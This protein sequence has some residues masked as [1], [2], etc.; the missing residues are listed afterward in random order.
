[1]LEKAKHR[2]RHLTNVTFRRLPLSLRFPL[3]SGSVDFAYF[4]HVS[5][6][7]DREDAFMILREMRRVLRRSGRA[8]VQFSLLRHPDNQRQFQRWAVGDDVADVRSRFYTEPEAEL[9][10]GLADLHP[11]LRLYI[12]GEYA[13]IVTKTDKR[14]LGAMPLVRLP[15]A[16]DDRR[17]PATS[18]IGKTPKHRFKQ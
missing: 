4:Y 18:S 6:H 15:R 2:C 5:E 1:M 17:E 16:K 9:I 10:L 11:Q 13:V 8:L 7:M 3:E 12:P 14:Q